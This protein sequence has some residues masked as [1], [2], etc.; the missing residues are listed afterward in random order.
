MCRFSVFFSSYVQLHSCRHGIGDKL[1]LTRAVNSSSK[2]YKEAREGSGGWGFVHRKVR[3]TGPGKKGGKHALVGVEAMEEMAGLVEWRCGWAEGWVELRSGG[4][5]RKMVVV[6]REME[7]ETEI[8]EKLSLL[9]ML[10][11][12]WDLGNTQLRQSGGKSRLL[13]E[14]PGSG[15]IEITVLHGEQAQRKGPHSGRNS[16]LQPLWDWKAATRKDN[17]WCI[18]STWESK[19]NGL[20]TMRSEDTTFE[21]LWVKNVKTPHISTREYATAANIHWLL[22]HVAITAPL[23]L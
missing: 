9:A 14:K 16:R 5:R 3:I 10:R 22:P 4:M 18:L 6:V 12:R 7:S 17:G 1:E 19:E 21:K 13:Q 15:K 23:M 8:L 20:V 11:S 2:K